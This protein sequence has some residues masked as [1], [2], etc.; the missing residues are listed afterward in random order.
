MSPIIKVV[1]KVIG[2]AVDIVEDVV[3]VVADAVDWV[4][5]EIIEPVVSTVGDIIESALDDPIKTIAKI[6]LVATGNAWALPLIDGAAVVANGGDIGDAL[7][8]AAVS[9]VAGEASAYAGDAVGTFVGDA[10]SSELANT[11]ISGAVR[12]GASA[13]ATAA[14]YGQDPW[15]AFLQGGLSGG[16][17]SGVNAAMGKID[18]ATG[19]KPATDT[20]AAVKGSFSKLPSSAQ[21]IIKTALTATLS[22]QDVTEEML[23]SAVM[24]SQVVTESLNDFFEKNPNLDDAQVAALT[25]AV[26]RSATAAVTGNSVGDAISKTLAEYGQDAFNEFADK[27]VK[28]SIDKLRGTWQ[29]MDA[30]A[31]DLNTAGELRDA[32][33]VEYDR[34]AGNINSKQDVMT[35]A[36]EKYRLA[37]AAFE[38]NQTDANWTLLNAAIADKNEATTAFNTAYGEHDKLAGLESTY[39]TNNKLVIEYSEKIS[40]IQ[41]TLVSDTDQLDEELKPL[42]SSVDKAFVNSMTPNFDEDEYKAIHGLAD[43]VDG[44]RHWLTKGQYEGLATNDKDFAASF[45]KESSDFVVAALQDAGLD[46]AGLTEA[47]LKDVK[48]YMRTTYGTDGT[49]ISKMKTDGLT[50]LGAELSKVTLGSFSDNTVAKI[51]SETN[52]ELGTNYSSLSD[53]PA[54]DLK[55]VGFAEKINTA[56]K[57]NAAGAATKYEK[58]EGVSDEDILSGKAVLQQNDDGLMEWENVDFI[59][60]GKWDSEYGQI[61]WTNEVLDANG[62]YRKVIKDRAGNILYDIVGR[63]FFDDDGSRRLD[64]N[65]EPLWS[66]TLRANTLNPN[67]VPSG[68]Q[69]DGVLRVRI[70]PLQTLDLDHLRE[71]NPSAFM[72]AV[73][74]AVESGVDFA[75]A[76]V[77]EAVR[78]T[79]AL[80]DTL[81]EYTGLSTVDEIVA[82]DTFKDTA[83]VVVGG[84]GE[85]L[86]AFNDV[87]ILANINPASTPLGEL[88]RDMVAL[89]GDLQSD[90]YKDAVKKIEARFAQDRAELGDDATQFEAD[91]WYG[92]A[93]NQLLNVYDGFKEAPGYFVTEFIAKELVQEVPVIAATFLT[94]GAAKVGMTAAKAAAKQ[95]TQ[96]VINKAAKR[97]GMTAGSILDLAE[98]AGGSAGGAFDEIYNEAINAGLSEAEAERRA[99]EGAVMAGVTGFITTGVSMGFLG[100]NEFENMV[101]NKLVKKQVKDAG[102]SII[103]KVANGVKIT[104]KEGVQEAFEE[105]AV[106]G[107]TATHILEFNP[108]Y[109]VASNITL[110]ATLGAIGGAGTVTGVVG[111]GAAATALY[112]LNSTVYN[113]VKNAP[114]TAAGAATVVALLGSAGVTDASTVNDLANV[115]YSEGYTTDAEA[116]NA[117]KADNPSYVPSAA[118]LAEFTG[119][120]PDADLAAAVASYIDPKFL[121]VDE[122]KAAAAAEGITLTDEQAEAYVG[123]KDEVGAVADITAEYDPQG[124]TRTEAEQFFA[125][126]GYTP[127]E[128]EI[129]ARVGAVSEADQKT[130]I[131]TYVNPRQT[132]EAEV[133]QAFTDQGYEPTDA[134]VADRIG[135]GGD[136]FETDTKT[137]VGTYVDPRQVTDEEARQFFAD[138]GYNDPTD[139]Q[140]AQF[141]AQ[142]EET[143]Q[144]DVISKYV[145]PRQVTRAEVQAIADEEGLTL[146]DALAAAYVGQGEAET[147]Q[148]DTL[149]TARTE[150]D[151]LA[152]TVDEA[153]QFFADTNYTATPEE[154]AEF[155]A[156]KTEEVQTSAIG[157]YV[158]PRQMTSDEAREFLS[159]IGYNPTDQE[160]AD[161]T[162]QLNDDSYQ[163]TQK[164]AIDEYVDPRFFDAG[165]VRAA[166]E[167]L[168]LVD[169]TQEDVDRFV[170]QYDPETGTDAEG[171]ES[172]RLDELRT[173]MPTATFNVIKSIM[174]SPAVED[175]PNTDVDESKDA[176][177][178]YAEFEAG[179]TRDEALEAAIAKVAT[180]LGTTKEDLLAEIG[181]TEERL[182]DEIDVVIDDVADVKEDVADVTEDVGDL[183]DVLGTA[184]VK[185]D[186]DTEEDETQDPTGLFATIKAYE[187]AGLD[188]DEALQKA[189]DDVAGALGTTKDELLDAIGESET[190]LT[191]KIDTATD[192]LTET[193][194]DVET[195]LGDDIQAVADLVGKPARDV[196]QTDIDF[197]IDLIA[198]ENVSAELITQYDVNA[199]GIVDIND[200]TMLETALQGEED[201]TLA[202]TSMFN[203][204]TGLYLKQEQDTQTT[205]DLV[206]ELNTQPNTNINTQS[207]ALAKQAQDTEFRRMRDAGMFEGAKLS[208]TTPDPMNIDYLYDFESIFANP[209]QEGLFDSPYGNRRARPANQ[210]AS[211]APRASGFAQGGQV[212]DENDMLLRILG[213]M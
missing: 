39:N 185:D 63:P 159:E 213:D 19:G 196:T 207:E 152:T 109:D 113:A 154:I 52:E 33:G 44:Y 77:S 25:L 90:S 208:A 115:V 17:N 194:G 37:A 46:V 187:D 81:A 121:D 128:E 65:G 40:S 57:D 181:L 131:A 163:T 93:G 20:A 105:G 204:A 123:Q 126:Q 148:T 16:V 135:Q 86:K 132:T 22:G 200:Q 160:V 110:N 10:T 96:E 108:D 179:A 191:G 18:A 124:T 34:I 119:N 1:E 88:A 142:V 80:Y 144:Q 107:V 92:K 198:Q 60:I 178:I 138:L 183:A 49:S 155:V 62:N 8:A 83:S 120:K 170:G 149:D 104:V 73:G 151:P 173:Y 29:E 158:D 122:V 166:Y 79:A 139:E 13:A 203:P 43:D 162:G 164:T 180:D 136:T 127:T 175:D 55:R 150:Y 117:F 101:T 100:G 82:S 56:I 54:A 106:S 31:D 118:E 95:M 197:V 69:E 48:T 38:E 177:G 182:R 192:T 172:T 112:K 47:Q 176:T 7:K 168:G 98:S 26:Q 68:Y 174:G 53:V 99:Q 42:Y 24:R 188:R 75:K 190:T 157:A 32:A 28:N 2:V 21:N 209:A 202:D 146:T 153:T 205:Q 193:I 35:T 84:T 71:T 36:D 64:E 78:N 85:L 169:V 140:V 129:T 130:A 133:R 27:K 14:V 186:P 11:I 76:E 141:V 51:L 61:V 111:G 125:D 6:A 87:L 50:T 91:T 74:N 9:Y 145:D 15:E 12:G 212:E 103:N 23:A 137:G 4:V 171:F 189:I 102:T 116:T 211:S 134:E 167:E 59:N 94:G 97:A 143:T 161:F 67:F 30:A 210:P 195:N 156:S 3:G 206:T 147:F 66:T 89:G 201:V 70:T 199:D 45:S 41:E 165:E 58:G 72:T 5:D 184:G 114:K